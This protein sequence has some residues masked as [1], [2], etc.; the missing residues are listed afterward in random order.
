MTETTI[1]KNTM[2]LTSKHIVGKPL[3]GDKTFEI[4]P[5]ILF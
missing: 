1:Q 5:E 4:D 2:A 3:S